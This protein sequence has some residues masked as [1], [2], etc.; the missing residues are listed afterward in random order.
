M[1]IE[2][3]TPF[4]GVCGLVVEDTVPPSVASEDKLA[5]EKRDV[6]ILVCGAQAQLLEFVD[7]VRANDIETFRTQT[8]FVPNGHVPI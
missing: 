1:T 8:E 2:L 5:A 6:A 4:E 7:H 3:Q